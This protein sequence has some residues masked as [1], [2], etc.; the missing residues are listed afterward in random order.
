MHIPLNLTL[1]FLAAG[2]GLFGTAR[3]K[4]SQPTRPEK[5]RLLPWT[6]IALLS[7]TLILLMLIN[8][9]VLAGLEPTRRY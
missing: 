5:P 7:G 6:F 9:A 4:L 8:L 2:L 3:W 1:V